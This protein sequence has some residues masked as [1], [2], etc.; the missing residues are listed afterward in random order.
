VHGAKSAFRGTGTQE[1]AIFIED[2]IEVSGAD[3]PAAARGFHLLNHANIPG[4]AQ[5]IYGDT[6]RLNATF[7]QIVAAGSAASA[8]PSPATIDPPRM[9]QFQ[10]RFVF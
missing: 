6:G 3:G 9:F 2:G 5:T 8:L 1:V 10:L 4:R 7:G